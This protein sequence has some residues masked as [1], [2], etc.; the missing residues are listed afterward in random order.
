MSYAVKRNT[1]KQLL[2]IIVVFLIN[3]NTV[4]TNM[5]LSGFKS[6]TVRQR[7]YTKIE[8]LARKENRS[9]SNLIDTLLMRN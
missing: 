8:E 1:T 2:K 7:T 3:E 9:M 6:I 5:T 4:Y